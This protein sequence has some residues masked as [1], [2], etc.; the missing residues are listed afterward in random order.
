MK[1]NPFLP[2]GRVPRRIYLPAIIGM[3]I[4]GTI[5][6]PPGGGGSDVL[7][8]LVLVLLWPCAM[9]TIQR[10]HDIGKPGH[11]GVIAMALAVFAS[12]VGDMENSSF[13]WIIILGIIAA[14]AALVMGIM[15][16]FRRGDVGENEYGPDPL[17]PEASV[18]FE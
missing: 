15:L 2:S 10:A 14:I 1:V 18:A 9:L 16:A 8:L 17:N 12:F 5:A 13:D 7:A 3:N 4:L 11:F 6:A